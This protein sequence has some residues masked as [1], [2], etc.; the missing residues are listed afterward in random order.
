MTRTI[1]LLLLVTL[2][3]VC[4]SA[5]ADPETD[6]LREAV[7]ALTQE[8]RHM[9]EDLAIPAT[10]EELS[11]FSGL[12][13]AA[14]RIYS[15]ES[16]ISIGGYGEFS[17][18]EPTGPG[19]RTA[20]LTRLITYVG[21]KFAPDLLVNSEIEF[22]HVTTEA[23][24]SGDEGAVSIEFAYLDFLVSPAVGIRAGELLYPVGLV[25]EM[26]EP[27]F[28]RGNARPQTE[29]AIIPSTWHGLGVGLHGDLGPE[30][31]YRLYVVES[32]DAAGFGGSG[33][34]DGRQ[35]GNR[36]R[37]E[38]AGVTA[39]LQWDRGGV[40]VGASGFAG[41]SGQGREVAG[42]EIG[43]TVTVASG[44][45]LLRHGAFEGKLLLAAA[46][47]DDAAE[48]GALVTEDVD[49][50]AI[51]QRQVGGYAELAL[52]V[53]RF[54][55]LSADRALWLWARGEKLD[56]QREVP[57]GFTPDPTFDRRTLTLGTEFRPH[58]SVALKLD[59][60]AEDDGAESDLADPLR[61]GAGFVF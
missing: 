40:S 21:Y 14:S 33:I 2:L 32:L 60:T 43:G 49:P 12:G 25:N 11:S 45:A 9:K 24:L 5:A 35:K 58:P 30:L 46:S 6:A 61:V 26:H 8:V 23:N 27:P 59:W 18:T 34:R 42:E 16:G 37:V 17:L 28:Y 50:V 41:K 7:D 57:A 48:I 55:G 19:T 15:R 44:H 39:R 47:I 53:G 22:E 1:S 52:E 29:R 3:A 51:P 20:D 10:D 38:D 4:G 54:L 13:P 31:S 56:L 36:A